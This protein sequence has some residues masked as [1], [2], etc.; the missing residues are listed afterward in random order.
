MTWQVW[1]G[2][3]LFDVNTFLF[4]GKVLLAVG[5]RGGAAGTQRT[6]VTAGCNILRF[7][8]PRASLPCQSRSVRR[9]RGCGS[10]PPCS[11]STPEELARK[12]LMRGIRPPL[13]QPAQGRRLM[14]TSSAVGSA[15]TLPA[16]RI[17]WSELGR[18]PQVRNQ[19]L[20]G[21]D[22]GSW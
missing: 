15:E 9:R 1:A 21:K 3:M 11:D 10:A 14:A 6:A 20:D 13:R 2:D 17:D 8:I 4:A 7:C 19:V 18:M 16:D 12:L 22:C 5:M